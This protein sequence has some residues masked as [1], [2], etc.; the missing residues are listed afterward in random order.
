MAVF[1]EFYYTYLKNLSEGNFALASFSHFSLILPLANGFLIYFFQSIDFNK[2]LQLDQIHVP[3]SLTC[4]CT[5]VSSFQACT[6]SP[7]SANLALD[8]F[9]FKQL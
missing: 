9:Y 1:S 4:R 6:S 2:R 7:A 5:S 8:Y 3:F